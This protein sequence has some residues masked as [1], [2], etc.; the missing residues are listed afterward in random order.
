M[1]LILDDVRFDSETTSSRPATEPVRHYSR[2]GHGAV[3]ASE[4]TDRRTVSTDIRRD[5]Q[6]DRRTEG[7]RDRGTE[8]Q[9]EK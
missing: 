3:S 9:R 7:Q 8:G 5:G 2:V 4:G 6:T 1:L